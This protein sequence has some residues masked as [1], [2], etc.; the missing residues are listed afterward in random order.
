MFQ[1]WPEPLSRLKDSV[2]YLTAFSTGEIV[3]D[4]NFPFLQP[5]AWLTIYIPNDAPADQ[6]YLVRLDPLIT[7]LA[8]V[9]LVPLWRK[10]RIWVLWLAVAL[11]FLLLW[12][13]KWP[14]YILI[15]SAPLCVSAAEGA[16]QLRAWTLRALR[17]RW[18]G[19]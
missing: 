15:L 6:P 8:L 10:E 14:H 12:N 9:G 17:W 1:L 18:G 5:L 2:F 7:G 3:R 4:A 13:T 16:L 11:I 19:T